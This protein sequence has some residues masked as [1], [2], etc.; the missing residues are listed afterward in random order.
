MTE[1]IQ[2]RLLSVQRDL[3]N[4]EQGPPLEEEMM[5][6]FLS[7]VR[8]MRI[9]R[10]KCSLSRNNVMAFKMLKCFLRIQIILEFS[11]Q[12]NELSRTGHSKDKNIYICLRP[13]FKKWDSYLR[14]TEVSCELRN[15]NM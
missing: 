3:K 7:E 14:S 2:T 1:Q 13:V 5:G 15:V 8:A 10:H 6:P 12:I 4:Y 9:D 11:D